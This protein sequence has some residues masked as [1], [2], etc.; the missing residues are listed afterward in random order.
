[1]QKMFIYRNRTFFLMLIDSSTI[2]LGFIWS[3][4]VVSEFKI[5]DNFHQ[6]LL[7][8]LPIIILTHMI[9]F[10]FSGFYNII[11]RFTSLRELLIIVK[12]LIISF[13]ISVI[14]IGV[15][16]RF[17]IHPGSALLSFFFFN[18]LFISGTRILIRIYHTYYLNKDNEKN[19][20]LKKKIILVGAGSGGARIAKEIL[21]MTIPNY[22]IIGFADDDRSKIGRKIYGIKVLCSIDELNHLKIKF[23]ELL[24]TIPGATRPDTKRIISRVKLIGKRFKI[25]P[26]I[27]ELIDH[28]YSFSSIRDVSYLDLLGREEVKLD[29]NAI[30]KMINGKRILVTGAGG[31][32]GSELVR[33]CLLYNPAEIICLDNNEESIFSLEQ[34]FNESKSRTIKKTVLASINNKKDVEKVFIENRPQIIFHAAAYKHVPIQENHPWTSVRTNIGGTLNLSELADKYLSDKFVLVSTDKAVNPV[35]VMGATKRIAEK[36]IQS[37]NA[38]SKTQ[39]F[40]VRFGNVMG[41]SGSAL[42]IFEKQIREGN[43]VT[44]THPEMT[45]YFMSITEASQLIL[46]CGAL[47]NQGEI[48]LLEM[49]KSIKILQMAKD[50]IRLSGLEPDIDIPIV[51]TGLRPGEKLY[52][53]LQLEDE[54]KIKTEHKKIMILKGSQKIDSWKIFRHELLEVLTAA[55]DLDADKIKEHFKLILPTYSPQILSLSTKKELE[56][57]GKVKVQA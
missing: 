4:F 22:E 1:M 45:R 43:P 55:E 54:K 57:Y 53:E 32:I 10:S 49:G 13:L 41:S 51:F 17:S 12:N 47:G 31:S 40:A 38:I 48:F 33:Q 19:F 9:I 8:W 46:Q 36:L 28:N 20:N 30:D 21:D 27:F 18:L 7:S 6:I 52:E 24:I 56:K 25:L 2:A 37:L 35:N 3:F 44:I 15:I 11:W 14:G 39:Y 16:T 42:P 29:M 23:D 34:Y 50:L 26:T 5:P